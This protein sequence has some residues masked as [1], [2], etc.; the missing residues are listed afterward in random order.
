LV[1]QVFFLNNNPAQSKVFYALTDPTSLNSMFESI[2]LL[3][4]RCT[5]LHPIYLRPENFEPVSTKV[6]GGHSV[7]KLKA[8]K[9]LTYLKGFSASQLRCLAAL[10]NHWVQ[11]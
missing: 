8:V 7:Q 9:L 6:N 3:G 11:S 1:N 10:P 2:R 4:E 5:C